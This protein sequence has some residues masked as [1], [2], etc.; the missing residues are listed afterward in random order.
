MAARLGAALFLI[1]YA[2]GCELWAPWSEG[3]GRWPILQLSLWL[4]N[5][6]QI[7]VGIA[8]NFWAILAFRT[9][10]GLFTAG[11]FVTPAMVADMWEP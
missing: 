2:F 11:A 7:F 8:P 9:L 6:W 5:I 10:G 1:A 4:V 3:L